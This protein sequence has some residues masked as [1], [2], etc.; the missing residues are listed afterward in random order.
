MAKKNLKSLKNT[1]NMPSKE[2]LTKWI[3]RMEHGEY[4]NVSN[5]IEFINANYQEAN[6][7]LERLQ[8]AGYDY[9]SPT[10]SAKQ[11]LQSF[12]LGE[13]TPYDAKDIENID[14]NEL[15]AAARSMQRFLSSPSSIVSYARKYAQARAE[16]AFDPNGSLRLN[17]VIPNA[18]QRQKNY[19]ARILSDSSLYSQLFEKYGTTGEII[20]NVLEDYSYNETY[21]ENMNRLRTNLANELETARIYAQT[22]APT[23]I[24][25]RSR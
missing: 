10:V 19:I 16:Y 21:T 1:K 24:G 5:I 9:Y 13:Y 25:L 15:K 23:D 14:E 8:K 18:T 20:E 2:S 3:Y 4:A 12:G 22:L 7:R 11:F 17:E 6:T